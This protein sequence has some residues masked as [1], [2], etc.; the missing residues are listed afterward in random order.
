MRGHDITLMTIETASI[1]CS[2]CRFFMQGYRPDN[3]MMTRAIEPFCWRS[4]TRSTPE[5]RDA[6]ARFAEL[7][8][9]QH[10]H[11]YRV[12]SLSLWN[13]AAAGLNA[14]AIL[15]DLERFSKYPLPDNIR[16]DI[17]ESISR[18]RPRSD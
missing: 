6:L 9:G 14:K 8:K 10:V 18:Y 16:V 4:T 15:G 11:T 17:T 7:E 13:A 12:S 1:L 3:P 5:A 2:N